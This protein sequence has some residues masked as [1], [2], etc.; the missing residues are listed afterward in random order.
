LSIVLSLACRR[1]AGATT[2]R[3]LDRRLAMRWRRGSGTILAVATVALTAAHTGAAR[4][5]E[6]P[7]PV[8]Q[9]AERTHGPS[10]TPVRVGHFRVWENRAAQ[11][12][13]VLELDL[14][15]L[16]A[17]TT[18]AA[19]DPVFII[20]GGPGQ[21]VTDQLGTW[22]GH[23]FRER[24]DI[25]L[26]SQ[27]GTGGDNRLACS[28][29]GEDDDLQS[30]FEPLFADLD[31]VR[32]CARE[33]G[34]R[35][36]LSQYSTPIAMDDLNDVRA[37]LG[38][39]QV[40]L[41]AGSYG[42][43]AALEYVRR[44]GDTV[45]TVTLNSVAPTEFLN[46]LYHARGAQDA[47]DAVCDICDRVPGARA[48]FGNL[49][50]K[51]VEV[52]QRLEQEPATATVAHPVSGER[53]RVRISRETFAGMLR[54]MQYR[55]VANLPRLIS[56]AHAGEFDELAQLY[57]DVGRPLKRSLAFGMLLCVTCG[58]DVARID[59]AVIDILTT[60]TFTG[61]GRVRQQL[62]ACAAWP[63][64][65]AP[66]ECGEPVRSEVPVLLLSGTFDPV[67][68]PRW[69]AA[70]ARHLPNGL[71]LVVPGTHGVGGPCIDAIVKAFVERGSVEG[72]DTMCAT[73]LQR[74]PFIV[75]AASGARGDR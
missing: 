39:R 7:A 71:H 36:D 44:H 62:A 56:A 6:L 50:I 69:G 30:Y 35:Y 55:D 22:A 11:R 59:P 28:L 3:E 47:F 74:P 18:P 54:L 27:R 53:V 14:V 66:A 34:R 24:R 33:L 12:G 29:G 13:R 41:Y 37:A 4:A 61:P 15:V 72:L 58:E 19:P 23:W 21:N 40:N 75:P 20:A 63:V 52:L 65:V 49:R 26:V 1:D 38:Y 8:L 17:L 45:R 73:Q 68:P 67:T 51:L 42:S 64:A 43:R 46:P 70:A 48:A 2:N 57:L 60:G 16:P 31:R 9:L 10:H 5:D 32:A 25:V